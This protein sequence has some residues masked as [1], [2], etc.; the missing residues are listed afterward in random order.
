M[1]RRASWTI[2][3]VAG[4]LLGGCGPGS[5]SPVGDMADTSYY[6]QPGRVVRPNAQ[7][8]PV[9]LEQFS[10]R[11]IW[12]EY[13]AP[14]C[15]PCV[16]QT[17]EMKT[18]ESVFGKDVVFLTVMTSESGGYGHPATPETAASW[19]GRFGLDPARVL[20]ADLTAMTIPKHILF[21]PD[22]QVLFEETGGLPATKIRS[23]LTRSMKRWLDWKESAEVAG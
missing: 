11:F 1:L 14:W 19:A 22:G 23:T 7:G 4:L 9:A 16:A 2:G 15:S 3:L 6:R 17:R 8:D 21:S 18:V 13:A 10:G 20:A 5:S 12:A